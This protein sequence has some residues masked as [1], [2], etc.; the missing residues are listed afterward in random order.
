MV[1]SV[2]SKHLWSCK[3]APRQ[4]LIRHAGGVD[5][6]G[7]LRDVQERTRL[8][9]KIHAALAKYGADEAGHEPLKWAYTEAGNVV[10]RHHK[11]LFR[12]HVG[13]LYARIRK[14]RGIRWRWGGI[15]RKRAIG[16]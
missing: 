7:E 8:K 10:A 16:C 2:P 15:W 11:V 5:P 13:L 6:F 4:G 1:A 12:R 3:S 14:R 9:Q